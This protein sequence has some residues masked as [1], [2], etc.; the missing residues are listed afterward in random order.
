MKIRRMVRSVISCFCVSLLL[1]VPFAS[2]D[3][4]G[5]DVSNWQCNIDTG[6]LNADFIVAGGQ[7]H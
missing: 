2:A 6:K 3:M 5:V 4:R 1:F 7:S